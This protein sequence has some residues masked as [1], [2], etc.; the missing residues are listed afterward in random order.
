[1]ADRD[2][3]PSHHGVEQ[4]HPQESGRPNETIRL[5]RERA[6]C[7]N[8]AQTPIPFGLHYRANTMPEGNEGYLRLMQEAGFCCFE[9]FHQPVLIE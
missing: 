3:M 1:M 8:Y 6:S 4:E 9:A 7:R 2:R 5:L